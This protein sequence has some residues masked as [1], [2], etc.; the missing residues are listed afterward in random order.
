VLNLG[1]TLGH[2][3]E[4]EHGHA[5]LL[6]GEA[7]AFGIAVATAVG[8]RRGLCPRIDAERIFDLLASYDLPPPIARDRAIGALRRLDDIRL[9]RGNRLNF[10]IPIGIHAVR[11]EAEIADAELAGALDHVLGRFQ[12]GWRTRGVGSA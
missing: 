1:H 3:L 5:E 2:A 7:V 11:I 10:V 12:A 9:A 6:H 8:L 4:V